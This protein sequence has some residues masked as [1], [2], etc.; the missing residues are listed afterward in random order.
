MTELGHCVYTS[1]RTLKGLPVALGTHWNRLQAGEGQGMGRP[2]Q[3]SVTEVLRQAIELGAPDDVVVT[4]G[5]NGK[6]L[7]THV[8]NLPPKPKPPI[9]VRLATASR[10]YGEIKDS[11]W[12]TEREKLD[13][14]QKPHEIIMQNEA[15][16]LSE[17]ASSNV[18][19]V[20]N[21]ALKTADKGVLNGTIRSLVLKVANERGVPVEL[22]SPDWNSRASW[23]DAFITSTS[24][25]VL[26]VDKIA[27]DAGNVIAFKEHTMIVRQLEQGVEAALESES[28]FFLHAD[29][30]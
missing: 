12:I 20:Q 16:L 29:Q 1:L 22:E 14:S 19:V 8:K 6:E 25:L 7:L 18:F 27:D 9:F 23:E 2:R 5:W 10:E 21:G 11:T 26:P 30:E 15:G 24:R 17:G 4:L 3:E 28:G 13:W